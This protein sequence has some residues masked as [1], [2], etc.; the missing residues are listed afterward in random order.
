MAV[1]K[2]SQIPTPTRTRGDLLWVP[3]AKLEYALDYL[4]AVHDPS[5][6]TSS[7]GVVV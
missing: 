1:S 4:I 2:R 5:W 7:E 6:V 3:G